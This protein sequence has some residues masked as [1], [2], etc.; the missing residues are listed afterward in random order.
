VHLRE[1]PQPQPHEE[2]E[3]V[4]GLVDLILTSDQDLLTL[5][6]FRGIPIITAMEYLAED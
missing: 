6:P 4:D 1:S 2:D 5:S 3:S